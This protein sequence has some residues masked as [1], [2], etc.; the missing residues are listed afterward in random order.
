MHLEVGQIHLFVP[1]ATWMKTILQRFWKKLQV[2]TK[3]RRSTKHTRR[4][5]S[6][7]VKDAFEQI[8]VKDTFF[9]GQMFYLMHEARDGADCSY[10]MLQLIYSQRRRGTRTLEQAV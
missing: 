6:R 9:A 8:V 2:E 3:G 1:L 7:N 4:V 5:A 10:N